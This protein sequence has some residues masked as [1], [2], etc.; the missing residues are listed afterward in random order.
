MPDDDAL[1]PLVPESIVVEPLPLRIASSLLPGTRPLDRLVAYGV[2]GGLP[3]V[4]SMLDP[5][6]TTGTNLRRLTMDPDGPLS[7]VGGAWLEKDVQ[8]P[9]RYYAV[10]AALAPRETDW[11]TVRKGVP[12][13]TGSGQ[14][15]PYIARLLSLG[16]V[17]ARKSLDAPPGSRSTRYAIADPFLAFWFRAIMPYRVGD[18]ESESDYYARV[19]RP[20][21]AAQMRSVFPLMCRQHMRFDAIETLGVNAREDGSLWGQDY[22]LPVAGL[23]TSGGAFYGACG[24]SFDDR[25]RSPVAR[26]ESAMRESRYGFGRER[27][28]RL[29]FTAQVAPGWLRRE[30][31]RNR[32]ALL[33][34]ASALLG[35]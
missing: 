19:V 4:L 11:A 6:L 7:D 1:L 13:V 15:A 34:D 35:D 2:F 29:V 28:V 8:T 32:D 3:K 31:A 23:L 18:R 27:R 21:L 16:L 22:D 24:W 26:I 17:T 33:I 9:T 30:V 12:D 25:S 14:L 20:A 10:M 5:S